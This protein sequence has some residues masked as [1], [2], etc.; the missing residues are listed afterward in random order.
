MIYLIGESLHSSRFSDDKDVEKNAKPLTYIYTDVTC[1]LIYIH[2]NFIHT[3]VKQ[4]DYYKTR[5]DVVIVKREIINII[6][7]ENNDTRCQKKN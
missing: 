2:W 7:E 4:Q 5:K 1:R 6:K 3:Y